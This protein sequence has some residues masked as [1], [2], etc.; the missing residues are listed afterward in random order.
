MD[1]YEDLGLEA[2]KFI[3]DLN[4]YEASRDGLFRMRRDAGN[5]P[6]FEETRRVFASKMTKIHM[7][8]QQQEETA[9][10]G[11]VVKMNG[12]HGSAHYTKDRP[13]INSHRQPAEAAAKPPIVSGPVPGT[14]QPDGQKHLAGNASELPAARTHGH[15]NSYDGKERLEPYQH[16]APASH[17]AP[18]A[19]A[20]SRDGQLPS[21]P[22]DSGSR[23]ELL[24]AP[25]ALAQQ[26]QAVP[27]AVNQ[28][29]PSSDGPARA[30]AGGISSSAKPN[31][32]PALPLSAFTGGADSYVRQVSTQPSAHCASHS[33]TSR[34]S[35]C[36]A[37][38]NGSL[39]A[40]PVLPAQ[41]KAQVTTSDSNHG[42]GLIQV[43]G[44]APAAESEV[45]CSSKAAQR[46][47]QS[48]LT[49][50]S[51]PG[52]SAAEVKL[53]ALTKQLE[54][55]MDVQPK[56]DYFGKTFRRRWQQVALLL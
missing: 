14:A 52:P 30:W 48:L 4:M 45:V 18:A 40:S 20:P 24:P 50:P 25:S 41:L 51:D 27:P 6:D 31:L 8:K 35:A 9:K 46:P 2:S 15:G 56:A 55:E 43:P 26:T 42:Q 53:D 7:Q 36:H 33:P 47:C 16:S 28:S 38:H 49:Q 11:Q 1:K 39:A 37:S 54:K 17:G 3:E 10:G 12:G 34:S 44:S 29:A 19:W 23:S 32:I 22:K 21:C 13:P 5:N